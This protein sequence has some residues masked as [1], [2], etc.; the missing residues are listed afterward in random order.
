MRYINRLFTL[1]YFLLYF[2]LLYMY[3]QADSGHLCEVCT[4]SSCSG[5]WI[6]CWF[7]ICGLHTTTSLSWLAIRAVIVSLRSNAPKL[8][9]VTKQVI[10]R[11]GLSRRRGS[12]PG[13]TTQTLRPAEVHSVPRRPSESRWRHPRDSRRRRLPVDALLGASCPVPGTPWRPP[14]NF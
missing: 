10:W 8:D 3:V 12:R 5:V 2:Y 9:V 13:K 7:L 1:L 11:L 6:L 4:T 14:L